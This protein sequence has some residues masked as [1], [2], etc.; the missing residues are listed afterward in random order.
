MIWDIAHVANWQY[1]KQHKQ[2]LIN[3]NNTKENEKRINYDYAVSKSIMMIEA[4]T[5]KMEQPREGSLLSEYIPMELQ[6]ST[7]N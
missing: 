3:T 4:G 7:T 5:L 2:L 6:P 1:S